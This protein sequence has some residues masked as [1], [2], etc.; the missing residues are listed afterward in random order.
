MI[1]VIDHHGF[2]TN[3]LT[4]QLGAVHRVT[5][6]ELMALNLQDYTH[7]VVTHGTAQADLTQLTTVPHI[8]VLAIGT[9]YQHLAAAYGHTQVGPSQPVYGQ[10]VTHHH[11]ATGIFTGVP[12]PTP[13]VS[14]HPWRLTGLNSATFAVHAVDDDDAVLAYRIQGTNHWGMHADPAA[15]QS[16]HG[17]L[18]VQ[19]FLALARRDVSRPEPLA[20]RPPAV[21]E[22]EIFTRSVPGLLNTPETFRRLQQGASAA[23]WLDSAAAHRSQGNTTMMG[24]NAISIAANSLGQSAA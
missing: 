16:S 14:Y 1:L 5:A 22:V 7:I 23:F 11:T 24:T 3:I 4:H 15:L 17:S 19:N 6:S 13:L 10:A 18:I 21:R 9:G 2:T 8:P 12:N 20:G